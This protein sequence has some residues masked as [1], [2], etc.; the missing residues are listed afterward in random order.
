MFSIFHMQQVTL[1]FQAH[2]QKFSYLWMQII[3]YEYIVR[4]VSLLIVWHL[5][6]TQISH[7]RNQATAPVKAM[8]FSC[9]AREIF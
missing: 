5:N 4:V 2:W 9:A 8:Y 3:N 7:I 6:L 1:I